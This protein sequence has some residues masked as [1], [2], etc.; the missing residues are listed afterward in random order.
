MVRAMTDQKFHYFN[1]YFFVISFVSPTYTG[2]LATQLQQYHGR[3][4]EAV[5]IKNILPTVQTGNL[6]IAVTDL[7]D[8]QWYLSFCR[9]S[10]APTTEPEF[11][12]E[13]QFT[14]LDMKTILTEPS[15]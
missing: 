6:H 13:R 11:A 5:T 9:K 15:P 14:K 3:I 8:S 4:D 1:Y 7:T 12:Y 2:A 10:N